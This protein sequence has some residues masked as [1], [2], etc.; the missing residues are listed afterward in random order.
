M[1][2]IT[3]T[4]P[5]TNL[6]EIKTQESKIEK[7]GSKIENSQYRGLV[8]ELIG[9]GS[10][11]N[12]IVR[13]LKEKKFKAV[14]QTVSSF[15]QN[16]ILSNEKL[17]EKVG[18]E[19]SKIEEK[20]AQV[21]EAIPV[22]ILRRIEVKQK[23]ITEYQEFIEELKKEQKD[24]IRRG[25]YS[26]GINDRIA[27]FYKLI[28]DEQNYIDEFLQSFAAESLLQNWF[29]AFLQ[30]TIGTF[31]PEIPPERVDEVSLKYRE[32]VFAKYKEFKESLHKR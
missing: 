2:E 18:L 4:Q 28:S 12:E 11:D 8:I 5:S 22:N 1:N 14:R 7:P 16:Y 3:G 31:I 10:S 32:Q 6:P 29:Y 20:R 9:K 15:R 23:L 25:T 30:I 27:R 17:K 19:L 26:V 21:K 13:I 24:R